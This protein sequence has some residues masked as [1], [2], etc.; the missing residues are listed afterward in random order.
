MKR[1][2]AASHAEQESFAEELDRRVAQRTAE[3]T[4][5]NEQLRKE[6]D[7]HKRAEEARRESE[8]NFN[9]IVDSIP[10]PVAVTS[11]TGEVEA[12]NKPTLEYFGKTFEEL[13]GWKSSDVV[14]PD[15]LE[16]TVAAQM[17]AHQ[18]GSSYNVES[19][20]R[21]ADGTYRWF[22]VL[23]LPL[24]DLK[25]HIL[26]WFILQIDIDDRK[27]AEEALRSVERNLNQIINTIPTHI[28]VLNTEGSVQYVNQAV[29]DFTGLSLEDVKQ[30]DYRDRV[31]HPE[32]FKRVRAPRAAGLRRGAPF[33][34]EQR[35]LGNDGQ[36]RWFLVRYKPLLDEQGRIVRW[37]VAAFDIED[38]KRA[39]A[40][41]AG[42]KRLLEMVAGGNTLT[43]I[44]D[45]LCRLV[46]ET[47]SGYIC[48]IL[49]LDKSGTSVELA[50]APSLPPS[51]NEAILSWPI[52]PDSGPCARAVFRKE[53]VISTDVASDLQWDAYGWRP[54]ALSYGLRACWS[55]P[56]LSSE[57]TVLGTF[58]LY[59]REPGRPTPQLQDVI[60]QMTHLTAVAI[61]RQ[62]AVEQLEAEQELL[63]L[64]QKSA[65]AMAFDW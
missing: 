40:L 33:S 44:L 58:A 18:A 28:Y 61:E 48:G 22:N 41:L 34:T 4:A 21:R 17:E 53:Q 14:H 8:L 2:A 25:G 5:A 36:Y 29:M 46:E 9:L 13:K 54:L 51:Y 63:D 1:S 50:R 45:A 7:E 12:L 60:E 19:R 55:T 23:G 62:R 52:N 20:H 39:E 6:L 47:A 11:P 26:R 35:V 3:L 59:S 57:N 15:D 32:D 64:A 56:I 37:Y 43:S 24:R 10:A 27:R 38:Q 49:L 30:E 31:I 16:R 65:R 42:E